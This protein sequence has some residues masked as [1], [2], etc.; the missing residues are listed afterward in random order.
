MAT[1]DDGVAFR[2]AM[3]SAEGKLLMCTELQGQKIGGKR[4][5]LPIPF[6]KELSSIMKQG[7]VVRAEVPA[8]IG[9]SAQQVRGL[10]PGATTVWEVELVS[11]SRAPKFAASA[12]DKLKRTDSGLQYEVI[13]QGEG[14]KP[15][16]EDTVVA[17]YTGWLPDGTV[18]DSSHLRGEPSEFALNQVIRGW[19]EGVPMMAEG[20]IYQFV[21]PPELAYG[22]RG[23]QPAIPPNA[24]LVFRIEL[25]K[26]K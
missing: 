14:R 13:K 24:T 8:A 5:Q 26:V 20:S 21:I 18:F 7:E 19:T 22:E 25:V 2:F 15:T 16:A 6:L 10:P 11:V 4:E 9:P 23:H 17:H 3:F 1:A 12:P